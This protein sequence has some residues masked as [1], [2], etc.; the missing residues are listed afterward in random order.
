MWKNI[1]CFLMSLVRM[2]Y[3]CFPTILFKGL[4][5]PFPNSPHKHTPVP[6]W[7]SIDVLHLILCSIPNSIQ[8][9]AGWH[10]PKALWQ[11]TSGHSKLGLSWELPI[12]G[13]TTFLST[14]ILLCSPYPQQLRSPLNCALSP[15]PLI[16]K[17]QDL[18]WVKPERKGKKS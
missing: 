12:E 15:D 16:G 8:P 5:H 1:S 9:Q 2:L 6:D 17:W 13:L 4:F 3:G 11:K 7:A 14:H 10:S 18:G